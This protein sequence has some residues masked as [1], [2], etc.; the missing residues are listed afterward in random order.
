MKEFTNESPSELLT[1]LM[2]NE[3][4]QASEASLYDALGSSAELQEELKHHLAVREA[5]KMDYEAFT[6]PADAVK[7]IFMNLGYTPPPA[8]TH[9]IIRK[10]PLAL[11]FLRKATV[12]LLILLACG[13]GAY[14]ILN[15]GVNDKNAGSASAIKS[16]SKELISSRNETA[17]NLAETTDGINT[18]TKSPAIHTRKAPV[19]IA[20]TES[21]TTEPVEKQIIS[22]YTAD[23][24]SRQ[25]LVLSSM[26]V[27]N[28]S[29][30]QFNMADTRNSNSES[31]M[32][33][34][35]ADFNNSGNFRGIS[36]FVKNL[37][38][39][40]SELG[41]TFSGNNFS[42]GST[43]TLA[44]NFKGIIE[45]G[46]QSFQYMISNDTETESVSSIASVYWVTFGGKYEADILESTNLYPFVQASLGFGSRGKGMGR[47][48]GGVEYKLFSSG[49][50]I[51]AGYD[52]AYL[53]YSTQNQPLTSLS[54]GVFI[55]LNYGF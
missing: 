34:Q 37:S 12:P 3:L 32:P 29:F 33:V 17:G 52:A 19:T 47:I 15:S 39:F 49:L 24:N 43:I 13:Y 22:D 11:L 7:S 28:Q 16:D 26:P 6:P 45:I 54:Q 1:Q 50:G 40:N 35:F 27:M 42:A 38:N 9:G 36:I 21:K 2:D 14:N 51:I 44:D 25:I 30:N 53:W 46:Q 55:G 10:S 48:S 23:N 8:A 5:V 18:N 4:D 31:M 41:S 20:Y